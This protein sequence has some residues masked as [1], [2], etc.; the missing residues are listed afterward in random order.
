MKCGV[1]IVFL[2]QMIRTDNPDFINYTLYAT[3]LSQTVVESDSN[4][5][6][7]NLL[8]NEWKAVHLLQALKISFSLTADVHLCFLINATLAD[9]S[10][11][12]TYIKFYENLS[13]PSQWLKET[14]HSSMCPNLVPWSPRSAG[15]APCGTWSIRSIY[16]T[17]WAWD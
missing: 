1:I 8:W 9:L 15:A 4:N 10:T 12:C 5:S 2:L 7:I 11:W 13:F 6:L 17:F 3:T 16:M 14:R